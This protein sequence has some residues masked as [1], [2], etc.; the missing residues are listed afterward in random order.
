MQSP[1]IEENNRKGRKF[2][3]EWIKFYYYG[4]AKMAGE[5]EH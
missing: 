5:E 3:E 4:N 2:G 1:A